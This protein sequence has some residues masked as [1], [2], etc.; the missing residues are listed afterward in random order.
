MTFAKTNCLYTE[1]ARI[2]LSVLDMDDLW[3]TRLTGTFS[4]M[5]GQFFDNIILASYIGW[6]LWPIKI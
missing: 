1:T 5:I 2:T 3:A 6:F 4:L